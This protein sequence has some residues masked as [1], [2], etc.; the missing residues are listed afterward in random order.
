M[1]TRQAHWE[2]DTRTH[3]SQDTA[4][5]S[6]KLLFPQATEDKNAELVHTKRLYKIGLT[7][8]PPDE[9]GDKTPTACE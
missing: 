2:S 8:V 1:D 3:E 7:C 9:S 4:L 6:G 5:G